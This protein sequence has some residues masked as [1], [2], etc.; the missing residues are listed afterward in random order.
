MTKSILLAIPFGV[1]AAAC[2]AH[3]A[4]DVSAQ[5]SEALG[6][7]APGPLTVSVS[8]DAPLVQGAAT[9]YTIT[10]TNTTADTMTQLS[11]ST[12]F[13]QTSLKATPAACVKL[14]GASGIV[15]CAAPSLAPGASIDFPLTIVPDVAGPISYTT[16]AAQNGGEVMVV[17]DDE[18]V[19]P[20]DTDLQITGSSNQ[21]SPP[22]GSQYTY[23]FKVKNS[24]PLATAGDVTFSDALPVGVGFLGVTTSIGSCTGGSS[25][26]CDLGPLGVGPEATIAIAVTAPS[27]AGTVVNSATVS[28]PAGQTDRQPANNTASVAVTV[29]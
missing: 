11:L 29:K 19:A 25:V 7:T 24:G 1:L 17:T 2:G 16:A 10:L 18:I 15:I 13:V 27:V 5:S 14:G 23:T 21:G 28:L 6:A 8:P 12:D 20:G 9:G 22:A 3:G 26:S 4:E